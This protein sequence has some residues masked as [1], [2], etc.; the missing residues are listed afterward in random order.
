MELD[1]F[2]QEPFV[3][4][5]NGLPD[6]LHKAYDF[7]LLASLGDKYYGSP[8][9]ICRQLPCHKLQLYYLHNH[10]PPGRV[11]ILLWLCFHQPAIKVLLLPPWWSPV[12]IWTNIPHVLFNLLI[13]HQ[14][15]C[16][17]NWIYHY[18]YGFIWF[19]IIEII[20]FIIGIRIRLKYIYM[21]L[22]I[23]KL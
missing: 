10:I 23:I 18:R 4:D 8:C 9:A 1:E 12:P 11:G 13:S 15:L 16:P 3:D 6:H 14:A 17:I 19:N 7:L 2:L 21:S 22:C 20:T 5:G